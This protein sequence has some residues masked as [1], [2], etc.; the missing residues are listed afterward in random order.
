[1]FVAPVIQAEIDFWDFVGAYPRP[2]RI[3][4]PGAAYSLALQEDQSR[5]EYWQML[6]HVFTFRALLSVKASYEIVAPFVTAAAHG[7]PR[8]E[9]E[10]V[11]RLVSLKKTQGT[12]D[13]VIAFYN[14]VS[15]V[16]TSLVS[17]GSLRNLHSMFASTGVNR[18]VAWEVTCDLTMPLARKHGRPASTANPN[19]WAYLSPPAMLS[20]EQ[21]GV[22]GTEQTLQRAL[23]GLHEKARS[24]SM[25]DLTRL[26]SIYGTEL[27][28]RKAGAPAGAEGGFTI[29]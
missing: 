21:M 19:E 14:I 11:T 7:V 29:T 12:V 28:A 10:L 5:E 26:L 20:L 1:M 27:R 4:D 6:A 16:E 24:L 22:K 3:Q 2:W 15:N 25:A 13:A 8:A 9:L 17:G 18:Q 23:R